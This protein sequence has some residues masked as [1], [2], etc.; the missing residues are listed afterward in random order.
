VEIDLGLSRF[1]DDDLGGVMV[2]QLAPKR[3]K[4]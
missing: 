2:A 1:I 3:G 4:L